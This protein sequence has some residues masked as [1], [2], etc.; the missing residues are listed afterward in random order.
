MLAPLV[1]AGVLLTPASTTLVETKSVI[2]TTPG[3]CQ[4]RSLQ[5]YMFTAI[6]VQYLGG[7]QAGFGVGYKA[8][9]GLIVTGQVLGGSFNPDDVEVSRYGSRNNRTFTVHTPTEEYLGVGV[10]VLIPW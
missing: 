3:C 1:L 8:K 5:D 9:N 10:G 6:S 7:F 2:L 4:K